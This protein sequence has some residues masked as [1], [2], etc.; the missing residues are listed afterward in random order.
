MQENCYWEAPVDGQLRARK[1]TDE[2]AA[3]ATDSLKKYAMGLGYVLG[4]GVILG[5]LN[6]II[7]FFVV[8]CRCCC[9][10]CGGKSKE[11]GYTCCQRWTPLTFFMVSKC[12]AFRFSVQ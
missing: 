1:Y 4:P 3:A 11:E 2:E 8:I 5:V 10:C 12:I 7:M 9:R 6:L